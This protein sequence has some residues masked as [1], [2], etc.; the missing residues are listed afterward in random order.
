MKKIIFSLICIF[1]IITSFIFIKDFK[2]D[3]INKILDNSNNIIVNNWGKDDNEEIALYKLAQEAVNEKVNIYK[4][5]YKPKQEFEKQKIVIYVGIGD[6]KSFESRFKLK[7]GRIFNSEDSKQNYISN[8]NNKDI[9]QIGVL[10]VFG[11]DYIIEVRPITSASNENICGK[12]SIETTDLNKFENIKTY[13]KTNLVF[14]INESKDIV[15]VENIQN[16]NNNIYKVIIILI[17]LIT[18]SFI[19][20]IML[21]YKELA[22]KKMFGFTNKKLILKYFIKDNIIVYL[23]AF[24]S[25]GLLQLIYLFF[26]NNFN[27][28]YSFYKEW[29][30]YQL[31]FTIMCLIISLIPCLFMYN[32]KINEMLKNK[33]PLRTIQILNYISKSIFSICLLIMAINIGINYKDLMLQN[34]NKENWEKTKNYCFYEYKND[35]SDYGKKEEQEMAYKLGI[36]SKKL[37]KLNNLKG[38]ILVSPSTGIKLKDMIKGTINIEEYDPENGNAIHVNS[39]YIREHKIL[40]LDD[41]VVDIPKEYGNSLILLVPNKYKEK[42]SELLESYKQWYKFT[43]YVDEDIH[44]GNNGMSLDN[45]PDVNVN[46]IYIKDKQKHFLY[47]P[48]LEKQNNNYVEDSILIVVNSEN[49]G[50][51]SYLNYMSSGCFYPYVENSSDSYNELLGDLEK[52]GLQDTILSTPSLYSRVDEYLYNLQNK[53]NI[54]IFLA[55][56][57]VLAEV[58]ITIFMVLNYV[59]Q[60]KVINHIKMIH[61]YSFFRRHYKFIN[62]TYLCL[63]TVCLAGLLYRNKDLVLGL[64]F[65]SIYITAEYVLSI[66]I[67]KIV[68]KKNIKNVIKGE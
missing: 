13:F 67:L 59:E 60:N 6:E 22:I 26:Y 31:I 16:N 47:N 65:L 61:G 30:P 34:S 4:T 57:V 19:Y 2:L 66:L 40:D 54:R 1:Y 8:I 52:S 10:N 28:V 7:S 62:T 64:K 35:Y 56:I 42:E 49:M 14:E 9:N 38:G 46:I 41:N 44:N 68:E 39:N 37:F 53:L 24:I 48:N 12:Y 23:L 58:L 5:V 45:Y 3:E 32:I 51:D 43:R 63:L 15:E 55:M 29:I 11:T 36:M 18:L 17:S 25:V 20:Y 33:K 21:N 50:G 27:K